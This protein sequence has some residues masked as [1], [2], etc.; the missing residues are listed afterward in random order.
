[1]EAGSS[2]MV[3][4]A[5]LP[6]LNLEEFEL[7]KIRIKQTVD[8]V[9]QTYP[10]ITAEEKLARKNKLKARS[11]LLMPLPN[12]HQLKFNTYKCAKTLMEAIEKRFGDNKKSKKLRRYF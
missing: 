10:P 9:E 11:T 8:G 6:I 1:M 12:E 2:T 3:T 4:A 5:K 7:W